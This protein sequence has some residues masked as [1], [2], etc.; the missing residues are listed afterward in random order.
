MIVLK[1][2]AKYYP[3][4]QGRK[5]V[6]R[7]LNL[8]IP[9][10]RDVGVLGANGAGKSTLMNLLARADFPNSGAVWTDKMI[11]W[12]LGV[13][14][15]LNAQATGRENVR[16]VRHLFGMRSEEDVEEFVR[17]FSELGRNFD[18]PINTYSSGMRSRY[19]FALSMGFNFDTYLIDEVMAVGDKKFKDKCEEMFEAKREVANILLVTHQM[20]QVR[21]HCNCGI[22]LANGVADFYED[23]DEAIWRYQRL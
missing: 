2:V 18:L 23:V 1:N 12:P 3:T 21:K 20:S 16:F 14:S 8:F 17:D 4:R 7:D 5:Y 6:F 15:G 11:S 9:G 22:L 10:D 13:T 19:N